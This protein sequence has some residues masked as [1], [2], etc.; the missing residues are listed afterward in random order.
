M[1]QKVAIVIRGI[2]GSGKTTFASLFSS[3]SGCRLHSVDDLH[4][5]E[6]GDFFW[7]EEKSCEIYKR[8]LENF[9]KDC[10]EGFPVVISDC[11]N[12]KTSQVEDYLDAAKEF[13]YRTYVVTSEF[14]PISESSSLNNHEVPVDKLKKFYRKWESWPPSEKVKSLIFK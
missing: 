11:V 10:K 12:Y 7:D 9:K 3:I 5:D 4:I 2:P 14:I 1:S 8:N 13:N 6:K